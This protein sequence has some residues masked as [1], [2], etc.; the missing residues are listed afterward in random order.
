[1]S[2]VWETEAAKYYEV[3]KAEEV[4]PFRTRCNKC[5]YVNEKNSRNCAKCGASL[6]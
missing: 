3:S 4:S 6:L 5:G 2:G 1:M